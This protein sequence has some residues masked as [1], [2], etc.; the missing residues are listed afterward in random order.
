MTAEPDSAGFTLLEVLVAFVICGLALGG[1]LRVFS[2][3]LEG[4][5][6]AE[7]TAR[8]TLLAESRLASVGSLVPLDG[9]RREGRLAGGYRWRI[10]SEAWDGG[11]ERAAPR[12]YRVTVTIAWGEAPR[13]RAVV[14][15][16]LR[17]A[18]R[19]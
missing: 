18:E 15:T 11:L 6:S 10:E 16:S 5:E 14:L 9:T 17:L 1:L 19:P 3:S 2:T 7:E 12:A 8:A 4:V 13:E